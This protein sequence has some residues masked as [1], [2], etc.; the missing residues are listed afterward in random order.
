MK[1][2]HKIYIGIVGMILVGLILLEWTRPHPLDWNYSYSKEHQRPFGCAL[3]YRNLDTLFPGQKVWSSERTL[4]RAS[5][6]NKLQGTNILMVGE[7]IRLSETD[8]DLLF[9]KVRNGAKVFMAARSL[10]RIML[11]SLEVTMEHEFSWEA[12]AMNDPKEEPEDDSAYLDLEESETPEN[13]YPFSKGLGS[14]HFKRFT[15]INSTSLGTDGRD[16]DVFVR[17]EWGDGAFYL[18]SRPLAFTNFY[19]AQEASY[20]YAFKVLSYLPIKD[21]YW[22]EHYKP[23]REERARADP[24]QT[25]LR[26]ILESP[27][28]RSGLYVALVGV[29]LLLTF[30]AKRDQRPIP[31]IRPPANKSLSYVSVLG[32]L[33]FED[34]GHQR[35]GKMRAQQF[36][37]R[38]QERT[39]L[40]LEKPDPN[41]PELQGRIV[42]KTGVEHQKVKETL[43][44]LQRAL[45]G[46]GPF[47]QKDLIALEKAIHAFWKK[48]S[49]RTA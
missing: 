20:P 16:R 9:K 49:G 39:G 36:L 46:D 24:D 43:V 40:K 25:P 6:E 2:D 35:I 33:Y 18:H 17:S 12:P 10:D 27:S 11:D 3:L 14:A 29:L 45:R 21:V 47:S 37:K 41:D 13:G 22:D 32:R 30:G 34:G 5:Q 44:A 38:L 31:V 23:L 8:R 48:G 4:Y 42:E 15:I 1:G 28:L 7:E 26:F 19:L